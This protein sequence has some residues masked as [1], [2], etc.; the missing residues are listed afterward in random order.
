MSISVI[1]PAYHEAENLRELL[2]KLKSVLLEIGHPYE[3]IIV[4]TV[5][6]T[7]DTDEVCNI[8]G[9]TYVNR[10]QGNNY[11]DA[12]RT[13]IG[14]ASHKYTVVMDA[15]GSHNPNDIEKFYANIGKGY[16]LIIGSRYVHGGN[17]HNG[18]ILKI[19]SY[20]LNITYRVIFKIKAKDVSNSFR[21][22]R[23]DQ[24]KRLRLHCDNFD[25]VQEIIIKLLKTVSPFRLLE[26]PVFFDQ[27]KHGES[28]RELGKFVLSYLLTIKRLLEIQNEN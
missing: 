25:I 24:I 10:E 9:C 4:D 23:T 6:K 26:V 21:M 5:I 1:I 13:G 11:G 19:M 28:K 18:I 22:Y 17:S 20:A 12:I 3:V 8:N 16:D 7:D 15:D 27:R 14:R 2:P